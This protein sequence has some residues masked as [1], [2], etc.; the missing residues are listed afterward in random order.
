MSAR[1]NYPCD[2]HCHT[3]RS[4]GAD[5]PEELIHHAALLGM[6]VLAITDHDRRPPKR[7]E[8][9]TD[10]EIYAKDRGILLLR[11]IE[12]SAETQ[13]EDVHLVCLGCDWEDP[14]FEMLES[15]VAKSKI[16][17]YQ[18]LVM[19]LKKNGISVS[20]EEVLYNNGNPVSEQQVQKKMLFELLARKGYAKDWGMAKRMLQQDPR[21]Q[22]KRVKPDPLVVIR[23]I[24]RCGGYV[25]LA[26]P[27]LISDP[28]Y[29]DGRVIKR[30]EYMDL[31]VKHGLDG[32]EGC[33]TYDK[34]SYNQAMTKESIE[35]FIRANYEGTVKLISGGS[36]YHGDAIKDVKNPRQIGECGV[37]E[38]YLYK[39]ELFQELIKGREVK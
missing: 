25:I 10:L 24:H 15:T 14:Y 36:D 13:V 2:L 19:Q 35:Q 38:E 23:E 26:H 32:I 34:T 4:D 17:G 16:S 1:A 18:E 20:W 33:Y 8:D 27:F 39:N 29:I 12:I 21:Y 22:V 37:T 28:L 30:K 3:T 9:G 6:K 11:G 31:L 5:T 7:I